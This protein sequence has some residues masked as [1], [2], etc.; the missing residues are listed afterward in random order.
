VAPDYPWT[1]TISSTV[2]PR[3]PESHIE[4]QIQDYLRLDS[5]IVRHLECTPHGYK[6]SWV[7]EKGMPDLLCL[8]YRPQPGWANCLWVEVKARDGRLSPAQRAWRMR[9]EACGGLVITLGVDC[10]AT[11]ED[12]A[13]WYEGSGLQVRYVAIGGQKTA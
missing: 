1:S 5:W 12:F 2:K 8:R 11:I 7:G 4:R 9:E 6:E 3:L 13:R 10:E